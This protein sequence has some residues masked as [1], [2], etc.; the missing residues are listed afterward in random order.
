MSVTGTCRSS[1]PVPASCTA[2]IAAKD[3]EMD[4]IWNRVSARTGVPLAASANPLTT[5]PSVSS[6]SVTASAAP[7]ACI[8]GSRCSR[9]EPRRSNAASRPDGMRLIAEEELE[10]PGSGFRRVAAVH[11]VLADQRGEVTPDR[12][13]GRVHR[14]GRAYERPAAGDGLLAG[15]LG[16]DERT[17]RDEPHEFVKERLLAMF[18]VVL[19]CGVARDRSHVEL[20]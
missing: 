6:R 13:G 8:N 12:S 1:R 18:P 20:L 2:T 11:D 7:G 19:L 16:H 9:N 3:F 10:L 17:A 15:D 4:P 5:T 14:V